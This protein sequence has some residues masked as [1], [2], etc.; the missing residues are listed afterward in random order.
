MFIQKLGAA[1]ALAT[2][3]ALAVSGPAAAQAGNPF[4]CSAATAAV[5]GGGS[6]LLAPTTA[7]PALTPCADDTAALGD[8]TV[9]AGGG[10]FSVQVGPVDAQTRLSTARLDGSPVYTGA[11][12]TSTV[13][14][15]TISGGGDTISVGP[16]TA[17]VE[18]RCV[19]DAQQVSATSSLDAITVDG[20][21]RPLSGQPQTFTTPDGLLTV[22]VN[23]RT[24]SATGTTETLLQVS[25]LS[26]GVAVTVGTATAGGVSGGCAGTGSVTGGGGTGTG[27]G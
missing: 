7:N 6:T 9:P 21:A 12:A 4:S 26:G 22:A 27:G 10:E 18:D 19:D 5:T 23:Q 3:G 15:L 13:Q 17:T 11:K 1:A 20:T 8:V 14:A 24:T 2:A 25:T 16:S